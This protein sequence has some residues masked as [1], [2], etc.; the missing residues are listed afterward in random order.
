VG[1]RSS[2]FCSVSDVLGPQMQTLPSYWWH[3]ESQQSL[4]SLVGNMVG[5][6]EPRSVGTSL[7]QVKTS[8]VEY[9]AAHLVP[10]VPGKLQCG[11]RRATNRTE[12]R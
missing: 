11:I 6:D 1:S 10:F 9:L 7:F 12:H 3:V 5:A 2:Y 8:S 4:I